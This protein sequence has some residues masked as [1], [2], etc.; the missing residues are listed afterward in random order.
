MKEITLTIN[1][2]EVKG[3]AGNTVLEVCKANGIDIPT[4][5]HFDGLT[6][7]GA[8]RMCV[9][10]I[11]RERRPVPSCTYPAGDGLVIKTKTERLE[12]YRRQILELFLSEHEHNCLFCEKNGSCELQDLIYRYGI[13]RVRFPINKSVE[14]IDD[15]SPV[16]SRDPNHCILCGRCVRACDERSCNQILS[17]ANRGDRTFIT[18]ELR[19]PLG[20]TLCLADGACVQVCPTGALTEK[21]TRFQGRSWE[22]R[23][24]QTTC[25]Y[26]GV[27]CQME[28]SI[29]D[30]KIVKVRGVED[31]PDNKGHL[32]VKGRFGY[33]YIQHPDR[34][35]TPLIKRNG[36]FEEASWDEAL[37]LVATKFNELKE[38]YGSDALAGLSSAKCTNEENYLFQKFMRAG[39]GTNN[40]DH[41]ARL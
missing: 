29:K 39:I 8:C 38:R 1:G 18:A 28:L 40:V 30:N 14:P 36:K 32:C 13:D 7:V 41:C 34:L 24:V 21:L 25:P 26:C 9:V 11:E 35:T 22:F 37:G 10:E 4:L 5:C 27:G 16:I 15:S 6:D 33:D 19:Q 23:K 2:R 20:N 12:K 3:Q 17:F 31:G